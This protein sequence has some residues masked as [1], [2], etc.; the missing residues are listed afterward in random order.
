MTE[1]TISAHYPGIPEYSLTFRLREGA[2]FVR[3][4]WD[5]GDWREVHDLNGVPQD[6]AILIEINR[7]LKHGAPLSALVTKTSFEQIKNLRA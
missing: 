7:D 4:S 3:R 5:G 2:L 1:L 6:D